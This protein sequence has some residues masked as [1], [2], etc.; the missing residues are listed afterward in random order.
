M[1]KVTIISIGN[2]LLSGR[3]LD[4]N[5]AYLSSKLLSVGVE[6]VCTY[7]VGDDVDMI[8][9]MLAQARRHADVVLITGGLGPTDDDITRHAMA[10]FMGVELEF[11]ED[12]YRKMEEF[13]D[14]RDLSMAETN[15]IQA[16]L[17]KG[18]RALDNEVGTAAGIMCESEGTVF[19][20]MPGVPAEMKQMFADSVFGMF[21]DGSMAIVSR[22]LHC[23]GTGESRI[24]EMVGDMMVRGRN[25]L[26]NCTVSGGIITLEVSARARNRKDAEEMADADVKKLCGI[27]GELVFGTDGETMAQAVGKKLIAASKTIAVAESCTGGLLAKLLTDISG[28]S[29]YFTHGWVT[30]SNDAKVSELSIDRGLIDDYGA[31][32]EQVAMA[33]A[34]AARMK[35]GAN[36]GIGITGIAGPGG[37]S[38]Q[39]PVGLVYIGVDIEGQRT[40]N[41]YIFGRLRAHVRLRAALTSLNVVRLLL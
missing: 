32:S 9:E 23:F 41:R 15:R 5:A 36:I 38:E 17:P 8:V 10:A 19:V 40:G 24:A 22:R 13:F 4:S 11:Y 2:E 7:T 34:T 28:A 33:M 14:R 27:L 31:V 39:K 35:S 25:P 1:Q 20:S 12:V 21:G 3:I 18:A 26:V 29:S 37:G 30:Y 6:T 16:Y